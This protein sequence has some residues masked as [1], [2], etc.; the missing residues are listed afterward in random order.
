MGLE[1]LK[2]HEAEWVEPISI[3]Y[4]GIRLH[5]IPPNGQGLAALIA[6]GI[7]RN[8]DMQKYPIDS[9]DSLHLQLEAMKIAFAEAYRHIAD[10][11]YMQASPSAFLDR[12]FLAERAREIR[13][14][15]A[16]DPVAKIPADHGTVYLT[17]ADKNGMMVS[18]IQ[19]NYLGFGSGIVIPG[20]GISM[21]N[22]GC[23]F[24]IEEGHPNCVDGGKRPFHTIIPGFVTQNDRPLMSFGVMGKH[25]QPQGHV[26]MMVR[27][28][29][30]GQ[31]P[32]AACDAPR[33]IV[34]QDFSID[35]ETG[36]L[37]AVIGELKKRGHNIRPEAPTFVSGGL[38]G[39]QLI[40]C[41]EDGYCAASDP[42]KDG[43]AV[44]F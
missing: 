9:A 40:F 11:S 35:L 27:I 22:R 31:N 13:M 5:E 24:T 19:S 15:R 7:L 10:P 44:G 17:A 43:L 36:F 25:M 6:L 4:R 20:T 28:F 41:L 37:P 23:G 39:A 42:R 12:N 21:Q 16:I 38:G 26:Q 14:H 32:Q 30:Y 33:W 1:D 8:Y 2:N 18:F 3:D 34:N 29:D